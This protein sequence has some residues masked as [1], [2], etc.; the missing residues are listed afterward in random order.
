VA[1]VTVGFGAVVL[2]RGGR[3]S[4]F[5]DGVDFDFDLP[6][7]TPRRPWREAWQ[8]A[9][10]VDPKSDDGTDSGAEAEPTHDTETQDA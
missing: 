3:R 4:G 6:D 1:A 7:W 10:D 8:T 2:T 5:A 9:R